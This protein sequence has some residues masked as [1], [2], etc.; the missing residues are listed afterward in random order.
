VTR[1]DG[2]ARAASLVGLFAIAVADRSLA[3]DPYPAPSQ[4]LHDRWGAERGFP[5]AKVQAI[6]QTPDGYLWIGT[7]KGLFRF[8]GVAFEQVP[9]RRS[10]PLAISQVLG[11]TADTS[12]SLWMRLGGPFLARYHHGRVE[13]MTALEANEDAITAM[14]PGVDGTLL[15]AGI[16]NGV[17]RWSG[18]R[19]VRLEPQVGLGTRSPIISIAETPD[20]TVWAGTEGDGLFRLVA[21][22]MTRVPG[23][24]PGR[25]VNALLPVGARDVWIATEG[26]LVRWN[27]AE[28]T[29]RGL[30]PVLSRSAA[31]AMALDRESNLWVGT[32]GGLLRVNGGGVTALDAPGRSDPAVTALFEDR[33]GG[34]WIGRRG[35][36]ERLRHA[37]FTTFGTAQGLPSDH[38]GPI[39]A[40]SDGRVWLAPLQ[41]GLFWL[42]DGRVAEVQAD[43]LPRDVVY[44]IALGGTGVWVGRRSG[45]LTQVSLRGDMAVARTYR[46]RDGLPAHVIYAVHEGRDGTVWAGTLGGGLSRL[47]DGRF[48]TYTT[49]DG[50]ASDTITAVVDRA[51]GSTWAAT[52]SGLSAF[53]GG[54]WR[55]YAAREGLPSDEV[56]CLFEDSAGTLWIG[57][58]DGLAFLDGDRV[59]VPL[60]LTR[61]L[62]EQVFGLAEDRQGWLWVATSR[63]VLRVR[64]DALHQG[65]LADGDIVEYGAADGLQ[66]AAAAR[67]HR[68]VTADVVGRIWFSMDRGLSVVDPVRAAGVAPVL[69]RIE[70]LSADGTSLELSDAAQVP[71]APHRVTFAFS[72]V[73]LSAPEAIRYRYR[74][75]GFDE[76]WSEPGST[77]EAVYTSLGPGNYRFRVAASNREGLWQESE[78]TLGVVIQ[79]TLWQTGWVRV[80]TGLG[81]VLTLGLLYRLRLHRI[82]RQMTVRFED[83]LEERTRIARDLHDTLLQ[84]VTGLLMRF[85]AVSMRVARDEPL[86]LMLD[87]ALD[88]G[89]EML[90]QARE[91]VRGL[92]TESGAI[93]DLSHA[94]TECARPLAIGD[95]SATF[96]LTTEG[97]PWRLRQIIRDE[98]FHIGKEAIRN[99]FAHG[100]ATRIDMQLNFS[101]GAF[102]M[103]V[104]DNGCGIPPAI[105]QDGRREG[106]WGLVGMRERADRAAGRLK[107]SS[108]C[109]AGT[110]VELRVPA[111]I[112][113]ATE[114]ESSS[115]SRLRPPRARQEPD[116]P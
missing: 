67:R 90:L 99:A 36:I 28:I 81:G 108:S 89:D 113:S 74:L 57:T 80:V 64:R 15:M 26:G 100:R 17:L 11:L 83:R 25:R 70:S 77:R 98:I 107:I 23:T 9:D 112:A 41:G 56:H 49:A 54:R 2:W 27:G 19:F 105:L 111:A 88:R 85:H 59:R 61:S 21:R 16:L 75:D 42:R 50:L 60:G 69:A 86:R 63:T 65:M 44:S 45:A 7:D 101:K 79:P 106:H 43:D 5:G 48:T 87:E 55:V 68:S 10:D 52:P 58:A 31:T 91:T 104:R 84:E 103:V 102:V 93:E 20:G 22:K 13:S 33:E 76:G 110:V 30:D 24:L 115:R 72:A 40:D 14:A 4:Y 32:A 71:P 8:D 34:L 18:P 1:G 116:R 38:N 62:R 35:E 73:S 47:K 37:T 94:F 29:A 109:D 92:R 95:A 96:R 114:S 51:D 78:A 39:L 82:T 12:G 6:S 97:T 3:M 46:A 53:G 66:G